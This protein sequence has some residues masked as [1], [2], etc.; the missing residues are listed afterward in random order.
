MNLDQ[1]EEFE[2]L[3]F[4]QWIAV[5]TAIGGIDVVKGV[6]RRTMK[7]TVERIR[8]LATLTPL[9]LPAY[10]ANLGDSF[11]TCEGLWM[12]EDFIGFILSGASKN[13]VSVGEAVVSYAGLAQV[14]S[15]EEIAVAL[16][17]GYVFEDVDVFLLRLITLI[18]DQRVGKVGLL[19]N[20]GH[21][22]I[23]YVKVNGEVFAV[24]V[25][26]HS[27]RPGWCCNAYRLGVRR[28]YVGDRVF[29]A[30]TART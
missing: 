1:V 8:R 14:S 3:T 18:K 11:K 13:S 25:R 10:N 23:F 20:N 5:G 24:D 19:L 21:I 16:P 15:D 28:W 22:N 17:E 4:K 7:V 26:W 30:T 9:P 12:S 2:Q 27:G 29:S 6:L